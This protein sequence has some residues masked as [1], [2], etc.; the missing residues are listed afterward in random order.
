M[1]D[2]SA[3]FPKFY[4]T[5]PAPCPYIKGNTERK[6]FTELNPQPLAY[7]KQAIIE[8]RG[9][10]QARHHAEELHHSLALVGFRRSQ[11]IAYRPACEDCLE[12]KSVRIPT[13]LFK[14]S[15][16][17]KRIFNKNKD[18]RFEIKANIATEEQYELLQRYINSRHAEGG[19]AGISFS[20]YKDMV[21]NSPISTV[22][23][24]YR[25][26]RGKLIGAALTDQMQDSLSMVY[27]FFE[28][29]KEMNNRSLGVFIVLNHVNISK[30]RDLDHIYLG[31]FVKNSPKMSYKMNFK[32]IEVLASNGWQLVK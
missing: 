17:Q 16:S 1:T 20:E 4:V 12:C 31:Y 11:E 19:M 23:I 7:D 25:D 32:P 18:I 5:A 3:H 15:K 14:M 2:Q 28:I 29:S 21:E 6:I 22:I 30:S 8:H 26:G 10:E 24:E 27:S 13:M 9:P